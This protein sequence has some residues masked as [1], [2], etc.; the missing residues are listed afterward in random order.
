MFE[1]FYVFA[2]VGLVALAA[3][4]AQHRTRRAIEEL[5]GPASS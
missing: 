5:A 3:R 2:I 1:L 4:G